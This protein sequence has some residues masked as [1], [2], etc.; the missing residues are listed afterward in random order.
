MRRSRLPPDVVQH[1]ADLSG[2]IRHPVEH[3]AKPRQVVR[4]P[5]HVRDDEMGLRMSGEEAVA[6]GHQLFERGET[7]AIR[8]AAVRIERQLEPALVVIVDRLEELGGIGSVDV[9]GNLQTRA[10][11]P[12]GI[13]FGII[14]LQART[15][16]LLR[17]QPEFFMISRGPS[18]PALTSSLDLLRY[19]PRSG[20]DGIA[21]SLIVVNTT[22][23]SG[24]GLVLITSSICSGD[25]LTF[26]TRSPSTGD[27]GRP[28][29]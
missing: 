22:I 7:R 3:R 10:C 5:S 24:Y 29:P 21:G 16:G 2:Q 13:E 19:V 6:F 8:I 15:V 25:R 12:D 17:R 23:R 9:H 11:L 1:G 20:A 14:E 18:R 28:S 27:S 26:P 4:V